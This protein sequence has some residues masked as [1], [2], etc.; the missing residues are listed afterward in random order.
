MEHFAS[1]GFDARN[2][3]PLASRYTN[4]AMSAR[5][6]KGLYSTYFKNRKQT[7]VKKSKI[8]RRVFGFWKLCACV[9]GI[10]TKGCNPVTLYESQELTE[11]QPHQKQKDHAPSSFYLAL[12]LVTAYRLAYR[13]NAALSVDRLCS[14]WNRIG[15]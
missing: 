3:Q 9:C 7:Y 6:S 14:Q 2:V 8:T 11:G 4:Y 5:K 13:F 15:K 10:T 1:P 12:S